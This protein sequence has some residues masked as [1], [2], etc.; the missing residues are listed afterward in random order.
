MNRIFYQPLLRKHTRYV[1]YTHLV[2]RL[3]QEVLGMILLHSLQRFSHSHQFMTE[4]KSLRPWTLLLHLPD[5]DVRANLAQGIQAISE[6]CSVED[7]VGRT[8]FTYIRRKTQGLTLSLQCVI[9]IVRF[10]LG[11]F[12]RHDE[13]GLRW[14]MKLGS[15][16]SFGSSHSKLA[17][18][19]FESRSHGRLLQTVP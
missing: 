18:Q 7:P 11:Q 15:H 6:E 13:T 5:L 1:K 4:V 19:A 10:D 8:C 3:D 14:Y 9:V 2:P 12:N 17:E 16:F